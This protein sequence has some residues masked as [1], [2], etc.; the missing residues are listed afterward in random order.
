MVNLMQC[1]GQSVIPQVV[2]E[3]AE[4]LSDV[5]PGLFRLHN[6]TG[7]FGGVGLSPHQVNIR[8]SSGQKKSPCSCGFI[9]TNG[10]KVSP[11]SIRRHKLQICTCGLY[12]GFELVIA[13]LTVLY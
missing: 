1:S 6:T 3:T 2:S 12:L 8:S 13:I 11:I 9:T 5:F 10:N 4:W 7:L